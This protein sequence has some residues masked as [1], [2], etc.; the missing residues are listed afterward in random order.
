MSIL[1]TPNKLYKDIDFSFEPIPAFHIKH[2]GKTIIIVNKNNV[3]D[4]DSSDMV[5]G[6][7][8]IGYL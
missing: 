1:S 5:V 6:D 3:E 7:V 2:K 4:I 8:V